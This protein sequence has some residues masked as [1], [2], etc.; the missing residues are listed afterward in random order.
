MPDTTVPRPV[1]TLKDKMLREA[2][3]PTI[4]HPDKRLLPV[5]QYAFAEWF[6]R[7][8]SPKVKEQCE[9]ASSLAQKKITP[10]AL[11]KFTAQPQYREYLAKMSYDHL[12]RLRAKINQRLD[13]YLA[14]VDNAVDMAKEVGDYKAE[15]SMAWAVIKDVAFKDKNQDGIGAVVSIQISQARLEGMDADIPEIEYE[16]IEDD[17]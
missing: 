10:H 1:R 8:D 13:G 9:M 15:G 3:D 6:S 16:V 12:K 11:R 4:D 14:H 5:W 2:G 17:E 7:Q